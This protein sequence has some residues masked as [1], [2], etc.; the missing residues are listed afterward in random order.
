LLLRLRPFIAEMNIA[1]AQSRSIAIDSIDIYFSSFPVLY[2][3]L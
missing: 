3:F 1:M 2:G